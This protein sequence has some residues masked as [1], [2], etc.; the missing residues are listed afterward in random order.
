MSEID[1]NPDVPHTP[2]RTA[3]AGEWFDACSR[4]LTYASMPG[5]GG[6]V[7]PAG[8][9]RLLGELYSATSRLPQMCD[10]LVAFLRAQ[11]ATGR[12]YEARGRDISEQ[13]R[14]AEGHLGSAADFAR[15][16]TRALQA[17]QADIAGLGVKEDPDE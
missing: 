17:V 1:L 4:F 5:K 9:Y 2:E 14:K 8:A 10:Q 12:L 16:L 6:L 7:F 3:E 13:A 15:G 11:E